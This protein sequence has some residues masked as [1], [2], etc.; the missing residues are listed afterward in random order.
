MKISGA[1]AKHSHITWR[2]CAVGGKQGNGGKQSKH[3]IIIML[4]YYLFKSNCMTICLI[5]Y[6]TVKENNCAVIFICKSVRRIYHVLSNVY[7]GRRVSWERRRWSGFVHKVIVPSWQR[8]DQRVGG[9]LREQWCRRLLSEPPSRQSHQQTAH[10]WWCRPSGFFCRLSPL[11]QIVV[12]N[13][14]TNW[15]STRKLQ[16]SAPVSY[17]YLL[18]RDQRSTCVGQLI[19][20]LKTKLE[21][22]GDKKVRN[23]QYPSQL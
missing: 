20:W 15:R 6:F 4:R 23:I 11:A 14:Q 13:S 16:T 22:V 21:I 2:P 12:G 10:F 7:I 17:L 5:H 18:Y 1:T 8:N 9:C 3:I 19:N